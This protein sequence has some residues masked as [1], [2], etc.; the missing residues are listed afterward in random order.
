[1][2]TVGGSS[3]KGWGSWKPRVEQSRKEGLIQWALVQ[4]RAEHEGMVTPGEM[5]KALRTLP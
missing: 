1:M 3:G 4:S 5:P 2:G